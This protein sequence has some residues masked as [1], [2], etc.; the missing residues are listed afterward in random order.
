MRIRGAGTDTGLPTITWS[1]RAA[2]AVARI[3]GPIGGPVVDLRHPRLVLLV[4]FPELSSDPDSWLAGM[5]W[6]G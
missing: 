2:G 1:T 3:S 5:V 4:L 6:A